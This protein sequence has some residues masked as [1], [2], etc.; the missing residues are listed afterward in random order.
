MASSNKVIF[1]FGTK[2]KYLALSTKLENA[3]YFLTD[4]G[5]L[6]RGTV[7]FGRAR[8]FQGSRYNVETKAEA[9]TRIVDNV[10]LAFNDLMLLRNSDETMDIFMYLDTGWIQ[11]NNSTS[12]SDSGGGIPVSRIEAVESDVSGLKTRMG[13]AENAI[14]ALNS[15]LNR[16]RAAMEGMFHFAGEVSDI[17]NVLNPEKGGVYRVG[18]KEYAWNGTEFVELGDLIDIANLATKLE[19]G[20]AVADLE[21]LIGQ[22]AHDETDTST[23]QVTHVPASGIYRELFEH[24]EEILPIFNG[25]IPGLVPVL[26]GYTNAQKE[27]MFMN[28]LGEWVEVSSEG[29]V[30]YYIATDGQRFT[31]ITEYVAHMIEITPHKWI[32]FT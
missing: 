11:L 1:K 6:Y 9:I 19:L 25:L 4:T 18:T 15:E 17:N 8:V 29:G 27:Q 32:E 23:G 2:A 3:L 10:P 13:T 24:P 7:P 14:A 16:I 28:A 31:S 5:E 26:S 12:G 22:K 30:T 20:T 21:A